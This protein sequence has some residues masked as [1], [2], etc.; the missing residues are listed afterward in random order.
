[1]SVMPSNSE[2]S[3]LPTGLDLDRLDPAT[4]RRRVM[5]VDD[6]PET[7]GLLKYILSN[8]GIDVSGAES[9]QVAVDKVS[10][11]WPDLIL[12]DL[13]MPE[14]DG[15]ETFTNIRKLTPAP[16]VIVSA[17]NQKEDIVRGLQM[18]A[19]DYITK[20]FHPAEL[21]A[22]V[23][24]VVNRSR[25]VS[26]PSGLMDFPNLDMTLDPGTR[27]VKT[28]GETIALARREFDVLYCLGRHTPR[29]VDHATIAEE[30]WGQNDSKAVNRIK[31][32][33]YLLR[34][35]LEI[36]PSRPQLILAREGLGYKLASDRAAA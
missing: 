4:P 17:K 2:K 5:I 23:N 24:T 32:V 16:V 35:K 7:V 3:S 26:A 31:Y 15:E 20:P 10:R 18:G 1:M 11:I 19:D 6:E 28:R 14:M 25:Q 34:R 33:I 36:N 30:V 22:R 9:G 21:I 12:L 8:A 29:W 13:M 27:E